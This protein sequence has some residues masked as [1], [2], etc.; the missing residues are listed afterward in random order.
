MAA[1]LTPLTIR[2]RAQHEGE[3]TLAV[4]GEI[5]AGTA[6]T[7]RRSVLEVIANADVSTVTLDMSAV[8]FVDSTGVKALL[9]CRQALRDGMRLT[10]GNPSPAVAKL[11]QITKLD[12]IFCPAELL[13]S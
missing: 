5:D 3:V 10:V 2:P 11:F 1:P 13:A 7:F 12:D 8:D 9:E 6:G 4:V